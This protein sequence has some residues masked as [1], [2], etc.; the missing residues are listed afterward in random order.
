MDHIL[1]LK[2]VIQVILRSWHTAVSTLCY[3][4]NNTELE[5]Q[6]GQEGHLFSKTFGL[7]LGPTQPPIHCVSAALPLWLQQHG[8][9]ADHIHLTIKLRIS[10]IPSPLPLY[11]F[12]VC[13][14][15]NVPLIII[16]FLT[17]VGETF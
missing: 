16:W 14:G 5:R 10:K 17:S 4:L 1:L 2:N 15:A 13:T 6:Q 11:A 12:M 3:G 8:H 9:V 7:A